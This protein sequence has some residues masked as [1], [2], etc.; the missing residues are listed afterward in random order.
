MQEKKDKISPSINNMRELR[1]K[2]LKA[3]DDLENGVIDIA[4]ASC[5][6]KISETVISGLKSEMQYAILTNQE[7]NIPFY[8]EQSGKFLNNNIIKKLK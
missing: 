7:P 6:A 2:V 3:F 5:I 8:G 4:H 1:S